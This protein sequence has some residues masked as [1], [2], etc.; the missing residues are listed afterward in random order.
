MNAAPVLVRQKI[1]AD[2]ELPQYL[3]TETGIGRR[4]R[5]PD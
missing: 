1:D 3:L 2:P 4:L 5:A